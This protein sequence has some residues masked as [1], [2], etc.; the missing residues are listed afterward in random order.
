MSTNDVRSAIFGAVLGVSGLI[1]FVGVVFLMLRR[2]IRQRARREG[3][4]GSLG[5][6][7]YPAAKI[8]PFGTPRTEGHT[9][10][11]EFRLSSYFFEFLV[12]YV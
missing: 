8:E 2:R 9:Y 12:L 5:Y 1:L 3:R 11:R 6:K 4:E 7:N 10:Y